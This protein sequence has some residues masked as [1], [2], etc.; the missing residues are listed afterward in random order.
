MTTPE[1]YARIQELFEAVADLPPN[2]HAAF[3]DQ[4]CREDELLRREV[5]S[6][7]AADADP[8]SF[9]ERPVFSLPAD[10]FDQAPEEDFAGRH[11]GSYEVIREIG[12]GGLGAVYLAQRFDGEYRKEAALKLIRR[13]LDTDDILRRFRNERQILAQLDHPNIA[14]LL[15]GGTSDDGQPYFVMEYVK[16]EPLIAYCDSH[17]LSTRQRLELF[18]KVCAG[19]TYAHQNLVIHRDLKPSNILVAPDSESVRERGGEPKLLDFGIAKLLTAEEENNFT[20]TAP[21]QRA[22]TPDYASPEQI[23]GEKITTASD[24]YS[25]G[26]ILYELLT[27]QRPYRLKTRA[28]EEIARAITEQEPERPS[29][30]VTRGGGSPQSE[31]RNPKFL[32]G[33]LDNIVLMAMRKEADRRYASVERF[34][35]DIRRHLEGRPVRAHKDTFAYRTTKFARRNTVGVGAALVVFFTLLGGIVAT[36]WQA[37]K[38]TEQARV[39]SAERDRARREETKA[40]SVNAFLQNILRSSDP[41]WLSV[42][43]PGN[44]HRTTVAEVID[45]AAG[46][47]DAE[48]SGQPEVLAAVKFVI[49]RIYAT[50]GRGDRAESLLR[51][52]LEIR[53][54][55]LGPEHPETAQSMATLGEQLNTGQRYAESEPLLREAVAIFRR[56]RERGPAEKEALAIALSGLGVAQIAKGQGAAGEQFMLEALQLCE[57]LKGN[58]RTLVPIVLNNLSVLR[59]EQGDVNGARNYL[60]RCLE[61]FRQTPEDMRFRIATALSNLAFLLVLQGEYPQAESMLRESIDLY[62]ATVGEENQKA[63]WPMIHLANLYYLRGEDPKALDG[64]NHALAVQ[65]RVLTEGHIDFARSWLV[66]GKILTRT[67]ETES[68]ESYLRKAL[69]LRKKGFAEG[70]WRIAEVQI[71]LGE[72]LAAQA[73][74]AEA[75][76]LLVASHTAL[77]KKLGDRDPRTQEAHRVLLKLNEASGSPAPATK[78]PGPPSTSAEPSR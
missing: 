45:S 5:E 39:A 25:L 46:R 65:G 76:E 9:V 23:K 73:R 4:S 31:I 48:L 32:R 24:V 21:N 36:T 69:E 14:R 29:T 71:A 53:R 47:M 8:D 40:Q 57:T 51:E 30:V 35:E 67:S 27:G 49:G 52:S 1:R 58:Q 42:R 26:V 18:R 41:S 66:L 55:V 59:G 12:R 34:S 77:I 16:G 75:K 15:D 72:C 6:L 64:I 50:Q 10:L 7:L 11:F 2:E 62:R 68:G 56:D 33:D 38:A 78:I 37:K 61:E 17:Q 28:P 63:T 13:G 74:H 60:E 19:V 70:H 3:L 54:K 20:Q 44:V 43:A 22:M